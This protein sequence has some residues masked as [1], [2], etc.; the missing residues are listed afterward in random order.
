MFVVRAP[1]AERWREFERHDSRMD[2]PTM[3]PHRYN[4]LAAELRQTLS[5]EQVVTDAFRTVAWGADASFY[6]MQP[7]VVVTVTSEDDVETVLAACRRYKTP[8]TFRAAGTSLSGQAVTDSVLARLGDGWRTREVLDDGR[9]IRLGAGVIG[10]KANAALKPYGR[11]LGPDPASIGAC[12]VGGIVANNASGMCC[13]THQNSYQTVAS[14]RVL[15]ADGTTLDTADATSVAGFKQRRPELIEGL[16]QLRAETLADRTLTERIRR[17]F[18]IKN[19][20]GYSLNALIDFEDPIDILQHLI[21]GSEGT[22]GFISEVTYRT[23]PDPRYKAAALAFYANPRAAADAVT[24]LVNAPVAAIELIDRAGLRTAE[25]QPNLPEVLEDL[26]PDATALLIEVQTETAAELET[27]VAATQAIVDRFETLEPVSFSTDSERIAAYWAVR[28]GLFPSVG[29]MRKAGTAVIIEDVAFPIDRLGEA[30]TDMQALF[31]RH[32]YGDAVLFGHAR[33]GNLHV[34][35]SQDFTRP[36]EVERYAQFMD[37]LCV[38]VAIRH[39]GSLKAEHGT[40]RNVAPFVELE[41]GRDALALMRRIKTLFDPA[42]LLNPGVILNDDPQAHLQHLKSLPAVHPTVDMCT[43]C[44]FCESHCPS[45][46]LTTSPRQRTVAWRHIHDPASESHTANAMAQD[47]DYQAIDT[48]ATCGLCATVCPVRIDTG[49]LIKSQ[50]SETHVDG[51]EKWAGWVADHFA[52]VTDATGLGL[53]AGAL[54]KALFGATTTEAIAGVARTVSAGQVPHWNR[55]VP[56]GHRFV[57]PSAPHHP[58]QDTAAETMVYLPSCVSRTMRPVGERGYHEALP[59][60]VARLAAR[61]GVRL[62]YP[63]GLKSLCCGQPFESKGLPKLADAKAQELFD[64]VQAMA[65]GPVRVLSDTSPCTY[66]MRL[67]ASAG[68]EV[69][70]LVEFLEDRVLPHVRLQPVR[71]RLAVHATCSVRKLGLTE[72]ATR[73]AQ[74]CAEQVIVP[75]DVE[76]CG[77]AGDRGFT[78]P[79][80]NAHALRHL[81]PAIAGAEAG[82]STSVTCEIGLARHGGVPYRSLAYFVDE[83]IT[84]AASKESS[85]TQR[86]R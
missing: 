22:L 1:P 10:A 66:R 31:T 62:I 84:A 63:E 68:V 61:A 38:L 24:A 57:A 71:R 65:A 11:K 30:V 3:I 27:R 35:F 2:R 74:A 58:A 45:H 51:T 55:T 77:F 41:W 85:G 64:A 23:V 34:V 42:G 59:V 50:R 44:G 8:V 13:G 53:R 25:A 69:V 82:C 67:A 48:C 80:L 40:G 73:V 78:R 15:F 28:K 6:R 52:T 72:Q 81:R 17:K 70:D 7:K 43:E 14:M 86:R 36:D 54:A 21:V 76:C 49:A 29:A 47:Y 75:D 37:E 79:E 19:T 56:D 12:M 32:G 20:T 4:E 46:L 9:F 18:S 83:A 26:G 33:D 16:A 39:E 60:V 5:A